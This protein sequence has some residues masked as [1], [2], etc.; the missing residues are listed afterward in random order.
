MLVPL[1]RLVATFQALYSSSEQLIVESPST[2]KLDRIIEAGLV[3]PAENELLAYWF[4]Q[5]L[6]VRQG[7]WDLINDC[8]ESGDR[9]ANG[10]ND[11]QVWSHFVVGYS[12]ACLLI[13]ND[14]H[15]LFDI[16]R[17]SILQRKF[18]EA[19]VEYR[20]P[21]KQYTRIFSAFVDGADALRVY[22]AIHDAKKNQKMIESLRDDLVVGDIAKQLPVFEQWLSPSKR[23]YLQ[24]LMTY[25]SHKLRRKSVVVLNNLL[26]RTVEKVG[27]A[28]SEIQLPLEK[29][30]SIKLRQ[31]MVDVLKPGDVLITR[32]DTALTNLFL[33]GFWPHAALYVGT[34]EQREALGV[35]VSE[36]TAISWSNERCV[37]EAL[38]DGVH[39]RPITETL[40]VDNFVVLRP[41]LSTADIKAGIERVV[42]HE[43]KLYNFD[44][45][46]F[47]SDRLVCSEVVYRA[48][49]GLGDLIFPLTE[50]A[51]RQTLSPEDLVRLALES[52]TMQVVG[53][54]GMG[55][56]L[57]RYVVG[58]LAEQIAR[59]SIDVG[60]ID[61]GSSVDG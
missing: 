41:N 43:G 6:S 9:I 8:L 36:A 10:L 31:K 20:I 39:F 38:K 30:A 17:H 11:K 34:V 54:F 40:A 61:G 21:R 5:Y 16:V 4:A 35:E 59:K 32:H 49:D 26:S 22:D 44:F 47:S 2:D 23:T 60:S 15:F 50:R 12:A 37:L 29:R 33:P 52:N 53:I 48:F 51:G 27:R 13:R 28:A 25:L 7:L 56:S 24:R 19:F 46:F 14:Q 1:P 3:R 58:E 45:D 57:T 18:N 42:R 55:R